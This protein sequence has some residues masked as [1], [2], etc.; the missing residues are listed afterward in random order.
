MHK[1]SICIPTWEQHGYGKKYLT[2]LVESIK[3]QTFTNFNIIISDHSVGDGIKNLIDSYSNILDIVYIKNEE[4]RGN[5][6]ANTNNSIKYADGDIIKIMFQDDLF[7]N[8]RALEIIE[9]TFNDGSCNWVANGCNHTTD[10]K[11]FNRKM[12]PSWNDGILYGNNTI[13]SP[14]VLSIRNVDTLFFDEGLVMLMDCEYYFQLFTKYGHPTILSDTLVSN[15]MHQ[16]QISSMYNKNINDE[17]TYIKNK[18]L[19]HAHK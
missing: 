6:P 4:K 13:S 14:S 3:K 12:V 18:Y 1:I 8:D 19:N 7:V 16:H 9:K 2:E 15:R 17:I 5:G 11:N 10:G